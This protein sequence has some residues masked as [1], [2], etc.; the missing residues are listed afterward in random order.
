MY[1]SLGEVSPVFADTGLSSPGAACLSSHKE[2]PWIPSSNLGR[3]MVFSFTPTHGLA[4]APPPGASPRLVLFSQHTSLWAFLFLT[5]AHMRPAL[6]SSRNHYPPLGA[7]SHPLQECWAMLG[8]LLPPSPAAGVRCVYFAP[9]T[10]D[11][12]CL[13]SKHLLL[14]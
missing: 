2:H 13:L 3:L 7:E 6:R 12:A 8:G 10:K 9:P 1:L 14:S 4:P 11:R 5:A